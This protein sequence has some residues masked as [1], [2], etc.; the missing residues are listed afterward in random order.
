MG[1]CDLHDGDWVWPQR[2]SHY[3]ERHSVRLPKPFIDFMRRNEWHIPDDIE[4]K[5]GIETMVLKGVGYWNVPWNIKLY[6]SYPNP[7][8]L[9]VDK[10]YYG[11][12][13]P[14]L[15]A[16]LNS[17][18]ATLCDALDVLGRDLEKEVSEIEHLYS[19]SGS[20]DVFSTDM[21]YWEDWAEK[22]GLIGRNAPPNPG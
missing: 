22:E 1:D 5:L 9:V 2:L 20:L 10:N 11:E 12:D 19:A 3:V 7:E 6:P 21:T 14:K 17:G 4:A 16:Y 8:L 13:L 18:R 15:V